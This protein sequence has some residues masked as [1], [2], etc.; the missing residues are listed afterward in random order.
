MTQN[1]T[2][3]IADDHPVFRR[4]LKMVIESDA[5][6]SVVAEASDGAEALAQEAAAG[7]GVT[8]PGFVL[9]QLAKRNPW[10]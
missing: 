4:G 3:I 1:S 10:S 5:R 7:T 8:D 2:I 9:R 6:L